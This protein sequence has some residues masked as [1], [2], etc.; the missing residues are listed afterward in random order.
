VSGEPECS[1]EI[2]IGGVAPA[3]KLD[4]VY[5]E[6]QE[7]DEVLAQS[8]Q[9]RHRF[10]CLL[11][12][13]P[14][15]GGSQMQRMG[16]AAT[17]DLCVLWVEFERGSVCAIFCGGCVAG[18]VFL[19]P[20][21]PLKAGERDCCIDSQHLRDFQ[22]GLW[23]LSGF[24]SVN[25]H[26]LVD[27]VPV[28]VGGGSQIFEFIRFKGPEDFKDPGVAEIVWCRRKQ[29]FQLSQEFA[30]EEAFHLDPS[31][32]A[33]ATEFPCGDSAAAAV[34]KERKPEI[35]TDGVGSSGDNA[36]DAGEPGQKIGQRFGQNLAVFCG[37]FVEGIDGQSQ[38]SA[39]GDSLQ[40]ALKLFFGGLSE[41]RRGVLAGNDSDDMASVR[42]ERPGSLE[43]EEIFSFAREVFEA[44]ME[45]GLF[46]TEFRADDAQL[47]ES[48][49]LAHTGV[50]RDAQSSAS[51][52]CP[53][54]ETGEVAESIPDAFPWAADVGRPL[55]L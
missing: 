5:G 26:R 11:T 44:V 7:F 16:D 28:H 22:F 19:L 4:F 45:H 1:K 42:D 14:V 52:L 35:F 38:S 33:G 51:G 34:G 13:F 53:G 17:D 49:R 50:G 25:M 27:A 12:C 41:N 47:F 32:A 54:S 55:S 39:A 15:L 29:W 43:R 24:L 8:Q 18:L 31:Q 46:G 6:I 10:F 2:A 36:V 37:N 21:G 23:N 48:L 30:A 40:P 20:T 9:F 3:K